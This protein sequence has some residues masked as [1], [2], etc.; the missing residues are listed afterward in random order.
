MQYTVQ[1]GD[2]IAAV[3]QLLGTDWQALKKNN[4]A[5]VGRSAK[6]GNWFLREGK[7]VSTSGGFKQI[8][9]EQTK[10]KL[11][12]EL[13]AEAGRTK[14][15]QDSREVVHTLKPGETIW[16]LGVKRYHVHPKDILRLNNISDPKKLQPGTQLR[17]QLPERGRTENVVASWYGKFHQG[18]PMANGDPYD[19][20]GATIAHK[21]MPLGTRVEL[22]NPATGQKV[23]AVVAD[24][25]P[26]VQGRDVD[27][28]YR[29]AQ[30]LS[31][32][33]KGVGSLVMRIL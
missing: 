10:K 33:E 22:E 5:A 2:T 16:E 26:Y 21:D 17:I 31:L 20:N 19:M 29:L 4:P 6:N 27:L 7:T 15:V 1:K 32:A 24:R 8:L 18:L 12:P 28:S 14:A 9:T 13:P 30:R 11:N 25:G 3:T 23:R